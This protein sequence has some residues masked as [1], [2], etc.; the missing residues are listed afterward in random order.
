[1]RSYHYPKESGQDQPGTKVDAASFGPFS[2]RSDLVLGARVDLAPQWFFKGT[3]AMLGVYTSS[4]TATGASCLFRTGD[5][6]L[7]SPIARYQASGASTSAA[8]TSA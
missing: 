7:P 3:M 8:Y 1:M 4:E 6:L 5:E 2:L